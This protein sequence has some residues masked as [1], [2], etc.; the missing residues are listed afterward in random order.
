MQRQ[1]SVDVLRAVALMSMLT[2]HFPIFLSSGAGSDAMLYFLTNHLLGGDFGASWFLFL[3]GLSQVLSA[4]KRSSDKRP[5]V[6]RAATRGVVI[7]FI[8]LL[9]LLIVQGYEEVWDWDVLT[10]I[11]ATTIILIPCRKA[12]SWLLLLICAIVFLITPWLRSFIDIVPY[13]GGKF[14]GVKWISDFIPNFLIDPAADYQGAKGI[15]GNILGFFLIGQ[16]PIFPWIIFPLTGFVVGRRVTQNQL[17]SDF[18]HLLITGIM[19]TFMG[20][21]TA[22]AGSIKPGFSVANDYITPL[23]FYPSSFSMIMLQMGILLLLFISLWRIFDAKQNSSETPGMFLS[24]CRQI[25]K[26]S[27]TIYV[28]HFAVIFISL[29]I[30]QAVTGKYFLRDLVSTPFA[31]ALALLLL[32]LYYP[33]LKIWDK[34]GGKY[35]MEWLLTTLMSLIGQRKY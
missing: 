30:I 19:F 2:C 22:S 21:L 10:L 32:A 18:P 35:G 16:F 33:L 3:A 11:G 26:Y 15:V 9:F 17:P 29:R 14:E 4:S 5:G 24:Y 6:G 27:F 1:D 23:S 25:S 28:S 31:F 12:P 34:A 7:F 13:Y 20:L 8:G